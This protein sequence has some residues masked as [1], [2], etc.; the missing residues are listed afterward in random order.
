MSDYERTFEARGDLY[1]QGTG[2]CPA[3]RETERRLL[4]ELLDCRAG[5][6]VGDIIAG[7]GYLGEGLR[8]VVGAAGR[9]VCLE[10]SRVFAAGI[11]A[12]LLRALAAPDALALITGSVDH[13]GSLA[14][15]HHLDDKQPHVDEVAR[16]LRPGGRF[17]VAEAL[18]DS[19]TARFLNGS[20]DRFTETGHAGRFVQ[21][22][23]LTARLQRAGFVGVTERYRKFTWDFPDRATMV[24]YCHVLFGLVKASPDEVSRVLESD[25]GAFVDDRG[26]HLPW[27]LVYAVGTKAGA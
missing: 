6:V 24:R 12:D 10:P 3:A 7:G 19:A 17:A 20:V 14:A 15:L 8:R 11:P 16:V 1:N 2:I 9:V 18:S 26:A 27:S 5:Q 22:G 4:I 23:E 25:L 13:V 21:H